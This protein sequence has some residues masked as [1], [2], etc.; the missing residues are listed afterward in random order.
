VDEPSCDSAGFAEYLMIRKLAGSSDADGLPV[1]NGQGADG[2]YQTDRMYLKTLITSILPERLRR[3]LGIPGMCER[4]LAAL[5]ALDHE[6]MDMIK[7]YSSIE[8]DVPARLS[9]LVVML[10]YS[11]HGIEKIRVAARAFD[12][13]YYLPFMSEE[14][15]R[16]AYSVPSSRKAGY[17]IG[18]RKLRQAFPELRNYSR[19]AFSPDGLKKRLAGENGKE[20]Y[21]RYFL[22]RWI[23][24]MEVSG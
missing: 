21:H 3:R 7:A 2:L 15:I 24:S 18:K 14:M 9:A 10:K 20:A 4:F 17:P 12:R 1:M 6:T 5:P 8:N 22:R 23:E 11:L 13:K 19:E 16:L